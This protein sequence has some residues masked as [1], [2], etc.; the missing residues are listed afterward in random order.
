M[1][2]SLNKIDTYFSVVL[3]KFR[4]GHPEVLK[5]CAA[6]QMVSLVLLLL[7]RAPFSRSSHGLS[8]KDLK[9]I[10]QIIK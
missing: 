9:L 1:N 7:A 3:T 10:I 5:H 8:N 2:S 4:E 6:A